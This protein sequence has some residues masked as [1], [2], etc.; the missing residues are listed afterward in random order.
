MNSIGLIPMVLLSQAMAFDETIHLPQAKVAGSMSLEQSIAAR[1]S[2]RAFAAKTLSIEQIGQLLWAAQG[3][4]DT[5]GSLRAAPSAGALYPLETY[6]VLP[7]GIYRYDPRNHELKRTVESDRRLELQKAS[8][9]QDAFG[10][11]PAVFVFTAVFE[12]TAI[13]YRERANLY[14]PIEV[15]H[16]AQNL[17]LQATAQGLAGVPI[18]AFNDKRVAEAL[19]LPKDQRPLYLLPLGYPIQ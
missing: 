15:G 16:A 1:R 6:V 13:K 17:L 18:G 2:I 9:D 12:R 7:A 19:K 3:I 8:L 11:A 10:S 14:V 5:K 4:T